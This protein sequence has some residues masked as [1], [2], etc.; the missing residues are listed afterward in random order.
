M[1]LMVQSNWNLF[2]TIFSLNMLYLYV[3]EPDALAKNKP[4]EIEFEIAYNKLT[5]VQ[6]FIINDLLDPKAGIKTDST[7]YKT[8]VGNLCDIFYFYDPIVTRNCPTIGGGF[9][10]RGVVGMNGFLVSF[11]Q[12][13]FLSFKNSNQ[14]VAA[15]W[16]ALNFDELITWEAFYP[17]IYSSY[18][19]IDQ[20]I[21][22]AMMKNFDILTDRVAR[23]TL[24]YI[25]IYLIIGIYCSFK[26]KKSLQ[27]EMTDWRK[28]IRSIPYSVASENQHLKAFLKRTTG[29]L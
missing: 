24:T 16:E 18:Q 29:F 27:K 4:I 20:L 19:T 1:N 17:F 5:H 6:D 11:I 8:A 25:A 28:M 2:H 10:T 12:K 15:A 26:I 9:M 21:R 14:T 3:Q 7:L 23:I 13:I 22:D